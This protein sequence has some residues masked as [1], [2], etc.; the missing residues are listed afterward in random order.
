MKLVDDPPGVAARVGRIIPGAVV[1]H[2]PRHELRSWIVGII[3]VVEE[4]A[5]GKSAGGDGVADH[6]T[7]ARQLILVAI[8][9]ST[10]VAET[11]VVRDVEPRKIRLGSG[12]SNAGQFAV[13]SIGESVDVAESAP[14]RDFGIEDKA[15]CPGRGEE[16]K[17]NVV[18]SDTSLSG[19]LC[20]TQRPLIRRVERSV[21][22]ADGG[23]LVIEIPVLGRLAG[24]GASLDCAESSAAAIAA[25]RHPA[26]HSIVPCADHTH[27]ITTMSSNLSDLRSGMA[28]SGECVRS[29]SSGTMPVP[30]ATARMPLARAASTSLG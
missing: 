27:P 12:G 2:S 16:P 6:R 13:G 26:H 29:S 1:H 24:R 11:E 17:N 15:V 5:V 28:M 7:V 20:K 14:S 23:G 21:M 4:I 3:V 8:E 9:C 19:V 18:V 10:G 30:T 22:L 25:S